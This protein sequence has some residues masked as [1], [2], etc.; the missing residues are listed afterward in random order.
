ME[1]SNYFDTYRDAVSGTRRTTGLLL[2][3]SF[4]MFVVVLGIQSF[5]W[6][7][8]Q[9][10]LN[11]AVIRYFGW[12]EAVY[13]GLKDRKARSLFNRSKKWAISSGYWS[14]SVDTSE[15]RKKVLIEHL[16]KTNEEYYKLLMNRHS[17]T[18]PIINATIDGNSYVAFAGAI[19]T[20]LFFSVYGAFAKE[21]KLLEIATKKD[22]FKPEIRIFLSVGGVVSRRNERL[23][24][25]RMKSLSGF[26]RS[27]MLYSVQLLLPLMMYLACVVFDYITFQHGFAV[28]PVY[29]LIHVGVSSVFLLIQ[30]LLVC[31][32]WSRLYRQA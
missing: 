8:R 27:R 13:K 22:G 15:D 17:V 20:V 1:I 16:R 28:S 21:S 12:E 19:L 9:I 24:V 25:K 3:T 26:G 11:N 14:E 18:I 32:L 7:H 29:A 4:V 10:E 30:L 5:S 31:S 23:L 2:A 6:Q